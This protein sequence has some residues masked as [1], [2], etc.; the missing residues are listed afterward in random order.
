MKFTS[1]SSQNL[2]RVTFAAW[3]SAEADDSTVQFLRLAIV[4]ASPDINVNYP[5]SLQS[6]EIGGNVLNITLR[7]DEAGRLA[8][9]FHP[10]QGSCRCRSSSTNRR[11]CRRLLETIARRH[12]PATFAPLNE[13]QRKSWPFRIFSK[14]I[15]GPGGLQLGFRLYEEF[16]SNG[17]LRTL[18][19]FFVLLVIISKFFVHLLL[20]FRNFTS[21]FVNSLRNFT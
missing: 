7:T 8:S 9:V 17:I 5:H 13:W 20:K 19:E 3:H 16:N 1:A 4:P 12:T 6:F 18:W 15:S 10:W 2:M 21:V 14:L 11:R